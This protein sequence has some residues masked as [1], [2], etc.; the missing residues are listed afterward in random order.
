M[1]QVHSGL[2]EAALR[3]GIRPKMAGYYRLRDFQLTDE[4]ERIVA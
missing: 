2:L 1:G 4:N 3:L